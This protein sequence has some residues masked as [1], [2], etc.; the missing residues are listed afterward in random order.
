MVQS[1]T[2]SGS[3]TYVSQNKTFFYIYIVYETK[4][5]CLNRANF[6]KT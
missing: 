6:N 3:Y 2:E 5:I 4:D 1:F